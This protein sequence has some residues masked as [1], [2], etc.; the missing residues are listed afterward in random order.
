MENK[1]HIGWLPF[2]VL[3]VVLGMA[4]FKQL[5]FESMSFKKPALGILYSLSFILSVVLMLTSKKTNN[6]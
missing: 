2:A 4:V 3:A 1:N 5:N 6:Q